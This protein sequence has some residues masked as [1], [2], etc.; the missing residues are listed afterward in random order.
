MCALIFV[1]VESSSIFQLNFFP[2]RST[3]IVLFTSAAVV[4]TG[5]ASNFS[6]IST[7]S[8]L[9]PPI[10]PDKTLITKFVLSSITITAGSIFLSFKYGA[11]NLITAP[12]EKIQ[13]NALL[14][15]KSSTIFSVVGSEY[16][17]IPIASVVNFEG[18]NTSQ[19][20]NILFKFS[21]I[22]IPFLVMARI[23]VF[24]I[25]KIFQL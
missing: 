6:A 19:F 1:T 3:A 21:P 5:K 2:T 15:L 8:S 10:C 23:E 16:H 18:A 17:V 4:I 22:F 20:G 14:F 9:A 12:N 13:I 24:S 7:V 25:I 11:I